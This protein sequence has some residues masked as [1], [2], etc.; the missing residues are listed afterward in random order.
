MVKQEEKKSADLIWTKPELG[1]ALAI[2]SWLSFLFLCMILPLVGRA[3]VHGSGSPGAGPA[4]HLMQNYIQFVSVLM[5]SL[6]LAAASCYSKL[7]RRKV[8][9]SPLPYGSF[10]LMGL[11]TVLLV[12]TVTGLTAI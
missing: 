7:Q 3:A 10:L 12:A 4:P 1:T 5:L 6:A 11:L 9:E 8:D 2:L